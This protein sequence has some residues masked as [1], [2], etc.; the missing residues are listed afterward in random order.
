MHSLSQGVLKVK[1]PMGKRMRNYMVHK[2][3]VHKKHG[4][5]DKNYKWRSVMTKSSTSLVWRESQSKITLRYSFCWQLGKHAAFRQ[6]TMLAK[7]GG[8]ASHIFMVGGDL[9]NVSK[10]YL[11][12]SSFTQ[13]FPT[14]KGIVQKY[15]HQ[16]VKKIY[17][18][19]AVAKRTQLATRSGLVE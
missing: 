2:D 6:Y 16:N 1:K 14:Y 8:N 3:K 15:T 4:S 5:R 18:L 7:L 13:Q 17:A 11:C 9:G 19:L 12:L 10:R